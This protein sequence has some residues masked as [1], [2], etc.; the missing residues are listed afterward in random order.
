[1][2]KVNVGEV[3]GNAKFNKYFFGIFIL[4]FL[5][6]FFDGYD[7]AVYGVTL[8]SL[9]PDLGLEPTQAGMLASA[10]SCGFVFGAIVFGMLADK[11]GR[12][13]ILIIGILLYSVF[14]GLCGIVQLV[15]LFAICRFLAGIGIASVIPLASAM[16]SEFSP[17]KNRNFL[18]TMTVFGNGFGTTMC[19]LI[20]LIVLAHFTWHT[21]YLI[22]FISLAVAALIFFAYPESIATLLK[23]KDNEKIGIALQKFEPS[24]KP[25]DTDEYE[26]SEFSQTKL[27][28]R[29]L[30]EG[31]RAR[32][33]ILLWIAFFVTFYLAL[34]INTWLPQMSGMM[35]YQLQGLAFTLVYFCGGLIGAPA[36]G[37][38]ANKFGLKRVLIIDYIVSAILILILTIHMNEILFV[39]ILFIAGMFVNLPVLLMFS[40]VS[41]CYPVHVRG[42]ALGWGSGLGRTGSILSPILIGAL[43]QADIPVTNVFATFAI[44]MAVG[45]ICISLTKKDL[46]LHNV[47]EK[48][49]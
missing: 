10:T 22:A 9:M 8:P 43:L 34:G 13:R 35:G 2:N 29:I 33:T 7:M 41:Q 25:S 16:I 30:F 45:A 27:P 23:K 40:Y 1:M 3:I 18:G 31:G 14:T 39:V 21:M 5:A 4:G 15:P 17:K 11:F 20:G 19:T 44:P 42:T 28:L 37:L 24:F 49:G 46:T 47:A 6:T 26:V 48:K 12:K 36:S 38:L 32:I